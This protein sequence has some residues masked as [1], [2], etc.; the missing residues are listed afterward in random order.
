MKTTPWTRRTPTRAD[1]PALDPRHAVVV[2]ASRLLMPEIERG[3][4][5]RAVTDPGAAEILLRWQRRPRP[6][7]ETPAVDLDSMSEAELEGLYAGLVRIAALPPEELQALVQSLLADKED[8][9]LLAAAALAVWDDLNP[10]KP[11]ALPSADSRWRQRD[12]CTTAAPRRV[13][14]GGS[15]RSRRWP[16]AHPAGVAERVSSLRG[17][18]CERRWRPSRPD[19]A[20]A[21]HRTLLCD[22]RDLTRDGG[23]RPDPLAGSHLR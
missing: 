21:R 3:L 7:V 18:P 4:R 14:P 5:E 23:H 8:A 16:E 20:P 22:T 12:C 13:S 15:R 1:R 6:A 2:I 19:V 17:S 9:Y 10:A 11:Q